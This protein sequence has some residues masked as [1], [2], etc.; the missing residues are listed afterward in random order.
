MVV[1]LLFTKMPL[2]SSLLPDFY[3]HYYSPACIDQV[4]STRERANL[5]EDFRTHLVAQPPS[6]PFASNFSSYP[7]SYPYPYPYSYPS[8]PFELSDPLAAFNGTANG[9]SPFFPSSGESL[10][11]SSSNWSSTDGLGLVGGPSSVYSGAT[12]YNQSM[13]SFLGSSALPDHSHN[14]TTLANMFWSSST[15]GFY[16]LTTAALNLILADLQGTG[17][18][19]CRR[20]TSLLFLLLMLGTVWMAVSLFNFNKT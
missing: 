11:G 1:S 7:S 17:D 19:V 15:S 12:E 2:P 4:N 14:A 6:L 3:K 10:Y 5:L 16:N 18:G 13:H 9:S 8:S 20:E